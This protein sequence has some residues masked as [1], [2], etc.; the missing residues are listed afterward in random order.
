[1]YNLQLPAASG[2]FCFAGS[3]RSDAFDSVLCSGIMCSYPSRGMDAGEFCVCDVLSGAHP[4]A[5][6]GGLPDVLKVS[7]I[8]PEKGRSR[9]GIQRGRRDGRRGFTCPNAL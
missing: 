1:M 7:F 3:I 9:Y 8:N 6:E 4:P 2:S 5:K